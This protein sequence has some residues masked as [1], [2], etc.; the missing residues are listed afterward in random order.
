VNITFYLGLQNVILSTVLYGRETW[1]LT[2][3]EEYRLTVFDYRVLRRTIGPRREKRWEAGKE[4]IL[5]SFVTCK[6]HQILI[7]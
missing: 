4:C 3:R 2:L 6:L 7:K 1:S 5:R